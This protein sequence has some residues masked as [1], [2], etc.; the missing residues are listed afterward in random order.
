MK[1]LSLFFAGLFFLA[2]SFSAK[3]QTPPPVDYFVGKWNVTVEGTPSGDGKM[4][5]VLESKEGKLA[6]TIVNKPGA[7]PTKVTKIDET[8]KSVTLYFNTN[9]Y[10]VN[11]TMEK[12]DED[13]VTGNVMGMFDAKGERVKETASKQ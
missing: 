7:Q 5:V 1:K 8:E 2:L 12:K 3:A 11:L 9:G 13:H 6:G 10:D 4:T